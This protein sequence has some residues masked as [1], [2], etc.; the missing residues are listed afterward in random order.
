MDGENSKTI[1]HFV[2]NLKKPKAD[3]PINTYSND[4]SQY[5][6]GNDSGILYRMLPIRPMDKPKQR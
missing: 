6:R 1:I 4:S 3:K 5:S 2:H